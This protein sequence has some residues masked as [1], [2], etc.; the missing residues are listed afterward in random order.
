MLRIPRCLDS[1]VKYGSE[2]VTLIHWPR[3][4]I[5]IFNITYYY[6]IYLFFCFWNSFLLKAGQ[7]PGLARSKGLGKLKKFYD[8]GNPTRHLPASS[9]VKVEV[10][11]RLTFSQS[12]CLG[13][14]HPFGAHDQIFL[15]PFFC[16]KIAL[17]FVLGRPL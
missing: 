5:I 3:F 12:V 10:T 16:R 7:T 9:I 2:V 4:F 14:G 6:F 15:F 17:L 8:I 11:L 13:V 1:R